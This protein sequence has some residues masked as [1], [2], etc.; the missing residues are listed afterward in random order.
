MQRRLGHYLSVDTM[1]VTMTD[2]WGIVKT[3]VYC[4]FLFGVSDYVR[5]GLKDFLVV[6]LIIGRTVFRN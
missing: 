6:T 3:N 2:S 4:H 5:E 1:S